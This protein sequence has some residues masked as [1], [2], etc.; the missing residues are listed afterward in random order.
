M[1]YVYL[2]MC[3][4]LPVCLYVGISKWRQIWIGNAHS[5]TGLGNANKPPLISALMFRQTHTHTYSQPQRSQHGRLPTVPFSNV[6]GRKQAAAYAVASALNAV[7]IHSLPL[8]LRCLA[9]LSATCSCVWKAKA[10]RSR[11]RTT[12]KKEQIVNKYTRNIRKL[13]VPL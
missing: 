12:V 5:R 3:V 10:S 6:P 13:N 8:L 11:C 2:C 1:C 4:C 9:A 7:H